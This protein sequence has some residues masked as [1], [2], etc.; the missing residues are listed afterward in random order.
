[1]HNINNKRVTIAYDIKINYA[2]KSIGKKFTDNLKRS[3]P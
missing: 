2:N 3:I 1:M